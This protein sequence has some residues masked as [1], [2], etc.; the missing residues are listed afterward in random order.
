M[1]IA[2]TN[3]IHEIENSSIL[4][5]FQYRLVL[6]LCNAIQEVVD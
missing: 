1:P 4:I 3:K 2:H 5:A 6:S